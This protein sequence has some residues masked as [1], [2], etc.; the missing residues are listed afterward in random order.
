ME[1]Q[2]THKD[3]REGISGVIRL[4]GIPLGEPE[5]V[6]FSP[7]REF[8][9]GLASLVNYFNISKQVSQDVVVPESVAE[10]YKAFERQY[11]KRQ[12]HTGFILRITAV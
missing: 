3:F 9:D 4:V 2:L 1:P 5:I 8:D 7:T 12:D 6:N 11:V 10:L